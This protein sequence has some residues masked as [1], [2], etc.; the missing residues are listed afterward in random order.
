MELLAKKLNKG[1]K[2]K[3]NP[4][5]QKLEGKRFRLRQAK[6]YDEADEVLKE[7]RKLPS[8]NQMDSNY[9]RVKYMRYAD[10]FVIC[11]DGNKELAEQ[12]KQDVTQFLQEK[13]KLELNAEKTL[14]TNLKI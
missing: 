11:I 2:K 6:R 10:D 14:I 9:T 5:Y 3:V 1:K 4:A 8:L 7:M 12:I 13:L